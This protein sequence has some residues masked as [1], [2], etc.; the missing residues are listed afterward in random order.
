MVQS[1]EWGACLT[2][3]FMNRVEVNMMR[4]F[5]RG[6]LSISLLAWA[7]DAAWAQHSAHYDLS[8]I[9]AALL[10]NEGVQ[11][12]LKLDK[13]QTEK[14][15]RLAAEVAA[16]GREGAEE[17][18]ALA[19]SERRLKMHRLMTVACEEAMTTLRGIFKPEQYKRFD[20]LVLQQRGITAFADPEIQGKLKLTEEQKNQVREL[21]GGVHTQLRELAQNAS[22]DKMEKVHEDGMA[23]Y[24]KAVDQAV[25]LLSAEQKSTWNELT[26]DRFVVKFESHRT[27][28][29]R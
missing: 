13:A 23:L 1:G 20:Q 15:M 9:R 26:G 19:E 18:Q 14:V 2:G 16:K 29:S 12:E 11:R 28:D 24:R 17:F 3:T 8:G 22:P 25:A 21:A 4:R 27:V 5:H 6:L 10:T 7:T